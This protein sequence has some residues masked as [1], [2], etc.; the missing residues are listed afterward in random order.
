[1]CRDDEG[2]VCLEP[3]MGNN[4]P[5]G[6]DAYDETRDWINANWDDSVT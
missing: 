6:A 2:N 1:M 3:S 5:V 4:S